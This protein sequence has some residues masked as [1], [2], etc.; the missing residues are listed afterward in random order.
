VPEPGIRRPRRRWWVAA[1]LCLAVADTVLH[2][3]LP[4]AAP[5]TSPAPVAR[6]LPTAAPQIS[7]RSPDVR[8]L[9]LVEHADEAHWV[10]GRGVVVPF[11][12]TG[13]PAGLP[14]VSIG[15]AERGV[16]V[17]VVLLQPQGSVTATWRLRLQPGD[18]LRGRL[19][20]SSTGIGLELVAEGVQ[21]VLPLGRP[22]ATSRRPLDADLTEM[23]R[24]AAAS[25]HDVTELS[26]IIRTGDVEPPTLRWLGLRIEPGSPQ[27]VVPRR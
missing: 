17:L 5:G 2:G 23:V 10:S 14:S 3:F 12:A 13:D 26:L 18:H 6:T 16:P 21:T 22:D 11:G 4:A 15:T 1:A 24:A 25:G 8:P 27:P 9:D 19:W 20:R 7:A